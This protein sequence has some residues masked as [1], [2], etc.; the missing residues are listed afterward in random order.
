MPESNRELFVFAR[1]A[2][3]WRIARYLFNKAA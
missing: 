1:K 3:T 2:G